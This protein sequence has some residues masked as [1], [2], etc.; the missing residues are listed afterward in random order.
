M[1]SIIPSCKAFPRKLSRQQRNPSTSGNIVILGAFRRAAARSWNESDVARW[2][3]ALWRKVVA[4][5]ARI[6]Q[7][8]EC[9]SVVDGRSGRSEARPL[10]LSHSI[11]IRWSG[12]SARHLQ[13]RDQRLWR[14][15]VSKCWSRITLVFFLVYY[16]EKVSNVFRCTLLCKPNSLKSKILAVLWWLSHIWSAVQP[17]SPS[18]PSDFWIHSC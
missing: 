7:F 6:G 17:I 14:E 8:A 10:S 15:A 13:A 2:C 3:P 11:T 4:V 16:N 1:L 12:W 18:P 9:T 5:N